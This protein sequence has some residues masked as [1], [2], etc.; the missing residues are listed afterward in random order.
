MA[1]VFVFVYKLYW[2]AAMP[3]RLC[4]VGGNVT[5][6]TIWF[7]KARL[8]EKGMPKKKCANF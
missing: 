8:C 5:S 4:I 2:D 7:A 6:V 1:W 3:I